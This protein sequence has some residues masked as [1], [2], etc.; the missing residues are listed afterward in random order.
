MGSSEKPFTASVDLHTVVA[1]EKGV[2]GK[3]CLQSL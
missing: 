3:K 2:G 1:T